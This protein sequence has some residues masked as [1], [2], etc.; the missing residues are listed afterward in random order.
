MLG[1]VGCILARPLCRTWNTFGG[2]DLGKGI[3]FS[4]EERRG[5]AVLSVKDPMRY[6]CTI[7][8]ICG[9]S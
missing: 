3:M 4:L 1:G 7:L 2:T 5:A 6:L 9:E 8:N